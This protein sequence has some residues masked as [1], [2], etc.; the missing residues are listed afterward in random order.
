[1]ERQPKHRLVIAPHQGVEGRT[2]TLLSLANQLIV[3]GSLLS[4]RV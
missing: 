2:L 4:P 1:M 3:L